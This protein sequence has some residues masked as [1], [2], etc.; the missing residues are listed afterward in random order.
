MILL[1]RGAGKIKFKKNVNEGSLSIHTLQYQFSRL[2]CSL[3]WD[4]VKLLVCLAGRQ[5]DLEDF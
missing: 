3:Y 5:S 4:Q 2:N 1:F